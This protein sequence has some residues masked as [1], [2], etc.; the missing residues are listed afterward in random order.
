MNLIVQH[1]C[2]DQFSDFSIQI[3]S[4]ITVCQFKHFKKVLASTATRHP[5][6][7]RHSVQ[8]ES[9]H[10]FRM[11]NSKMN[12]KNTVGKGLRRPIKWML[13]GGAGVTGAAGTAKFKEAMDI[14]VGTVDGDEKGMHQFKYGNGGIVDW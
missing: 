13:M 10:L 6:I 7:L 1:F 5:R 9:S 3:L 4:S 2:F 11:Q 12:Q 14:N 8:Q